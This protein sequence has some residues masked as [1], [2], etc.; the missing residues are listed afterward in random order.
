[1]VVLKDHRKRTGIKA[2]L[3]IDGEQDPQVEQEKPSK[4][5]PRPIRENKEMTRLDI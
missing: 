2:E 5:P 4:A 1:V 3:M